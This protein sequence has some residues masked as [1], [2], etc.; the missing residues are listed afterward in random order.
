MAQDLSIELPDSTMFVTTRTMASRLWF[1]RNDRLVEKVLAFLAKYQETYQVI[2]YGF[3]LIG[4]HY[5]LLAK[6]PRG[7]KAAFLR[8]FNSIVARLVGKNVPTFEDGKL[9]AR[10]ARVQIVPNQEDILD[11]FLYLTCNPVSSGICQR[12]SDFDGYNSLHD[13]LRREGRKFTLVDWADYQN[14]SRNNKKLHPRDCEK[15]YTLTYSQLPGMEQLTS[16]EY[17][18]KILELV[19]LRR[20]GIIEAR[21]KTGKRFPPLSA[22]RKIRPGATPV[23]TKISKRD[24]MRP[25]VLTL[26]AKTKQ[27]FLDFYF[28]LLSSY[29]EASKRF[30]SGDYAVKFPPGTYRPIVQVSP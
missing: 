27:I 25:L 15:V 26:C 1:L 11:R 29:K 22:I 28:A 4:N 9:W 8:S 21:I 17:R 5:H 14:R 3:I 6:F 24:T 18:A 13:S 19:E 20:K 7:N 23:T 30:R 2:I 16:S 10:R 12:L